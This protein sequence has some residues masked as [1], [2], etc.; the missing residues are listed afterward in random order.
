MGS[1]NEV[2]PHSLL[3]DRTMNTVR[4]LAE[5]DAGVQLL[6]MDAGNA[7]APID[8]SRDEIRWSRRFMAGH[9]DDTAFASRRDGII[10]H[11]GRQQRA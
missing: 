11:G 6:Q 5:A 2:A 9:F 8:S 4:Q 3:M 7:D 1:L 10:A